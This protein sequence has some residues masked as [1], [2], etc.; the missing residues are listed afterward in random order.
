MLLLVYLKGVLRVELL[1]TKLILVRLFLSFE[2]FKGDLAV[3]PL[4]NLLFREETDLSAPAE[5]LEDFED[6]VEQS[7]KLFE[8]PRKGFFEMVRH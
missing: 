3:V 4:Q 1:E 6:G 5:E 7:E 8:L 2:R